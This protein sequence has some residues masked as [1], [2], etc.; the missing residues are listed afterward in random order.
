MSDANARRLLVTGGAGFLGRHVV[1]ASH[2]QGWEVVA[3]T[4]AQLDVRDRDAVL[5]CTREVR[6]A[7]VVHT[8]YRRDDRPSIVDASVHVATAASAA[9]AYLVHVSSDAL[10]AG[11]PD[12]YAE[13][14]PPDPVHDYGRAKADAE[15]GV[16]AAGGQS[17]IVRT[18]LLVGGE[19]LS[20]HEA[21][22]RD[23]ISGERPMSFFTDEVRSPLLVED[24]AAALVDL[25]TAAEFTGV[26]H[27][28][29]PVP[30]S[31]A[32]I[33]VAAARR[34]GWDVDRL[35]SAT[36]AETGT[37]RPGRVVLDSSRAARLG[38]RVRPPF[39]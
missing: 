13:T 34:H 26:L 22:V 38:L 12:P 7:A 2:D 21:A 35:R 29:G 24:L 16:G 8:A 20:V 28:G 32:E 27:V 9:G 17:V 37:A 23:A 11:R 1:R 33:A 31:R 5:A 19:A 3:P 6:P 15:V 4:S 36:L 39:A 18:S 25:A 14:D 10:F 30:M